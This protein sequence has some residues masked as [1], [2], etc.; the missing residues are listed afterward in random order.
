VKARTRSLALAAALATLLVAVVA[1]ALL[2]VERPDSA[3]RA[4]HD[5]DG[6]A[7]PFRPA[8][9]AAISIASRGG[10]GVRL[11]RGGA[12]WNL[13]PRGGEASTVAV[14]G[15]LE[16]LSGM[17]VRSA[18]PAGPGGLA[19]RGLDPPAARLTLTFRD[20]S[21]LALDLGDESTFDRTRFGRRNGAILAI[22][23]VPDAVLDPAPERLLAPAGADRPG[24]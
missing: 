15:L 4:R 19:S 20:G 1:G 10:P 6:R 11:V 14:E 24:G 7:L 23:G 3:A 2:G 9:V 13:L 8:D 16:R 5:R 17:R 12:G 22:E 18:S 21:E